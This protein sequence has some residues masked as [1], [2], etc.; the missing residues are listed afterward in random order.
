MKGQFYYLNVVF[1][2]LKVFLKMFFTNCNPF[3]HVLFSVTIYL[4]FL[5]LKR[6]Y[7]ISYGCDIKCLRQAN[8]TLWNYCKDFIVIFSFTDSVC[9]YV[10]ICVYTWVHMRRHTCVCVPT[11]DIPAVE[12][13]EGGS[14]KT[15]DSGLSGIKECGSVRIPIS[16][17]AISTPFSLSYSTPVSLSLSHTK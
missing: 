4:L 13:W 6:L 5:L 1:L 3:K 8:P 15:L 9:M 17:K 7:E 10:C 2:K 16:V 14:H 11:D 12:T